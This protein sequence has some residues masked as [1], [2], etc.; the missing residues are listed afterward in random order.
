L[1]ASTNRLNSPASYDAAGHLQYW[2]GY[3]YSYNDLGQLLTATGTGVN[4]TYLYTASGERIADRNHL[5]NTTTLTLRN[6]D[7]HLLR[8]YLET[9]TSGNGNTTWVE[10]EVWGG[11]QL[12]GTI[13]PTAGKRYYAVDHLGTPRLI[14][15]RC[16]D[17]KAE[18]DYYAFGLEA[19]DPTQD[20]E[21]TRFTSQETDLQN[22]SG[23]TDD[24]VNMHARFYRPALARFLSADLLSGNP[25]RPQSFNLFAYVRGNPTNFWDPY[26]FGDDD[27]KVV[28]PSKVR[29][30]YPS[31]YFT[32]YTEVTAPFP[33]TDLIYLYSYVYPG[34]VPVVTWA[35]AAAA[36][37]TAT[38]SSTPSA[39]SDP[40][41][42]ITVPFAPAGANLAANIR[43]VQHQWWLGSLQLRL[44]AFYLHVHNHGPWDYKQI[45][46]LSDFGEL[47]RPSPYEDFG[48]F[49]YGA[50]GAAAGIPLWLVQRAAG[51]ASLRAESSR[52]ARLGH[53]WGAFPYGD[54]VRDQAEIIEG[55]YYYKGG[56]YK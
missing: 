54:E 36:S 12:L 32:G 1:N 21:P 52:A 29:P 34:G 25:H 53:P 23:Q 14:C 43:T 38:P 39:T 49:N 30:N 13:S 27:N 45:T 10:D 46:L 11:G 35:T 2:G 37:P 5:N 17:R 26:G 40:C 3:S 7:G 41:E 24:L 56:C 15:D 16:K 42:Q 20:A 19:S 50:T 9:G 31:L 33:W 47:E 51:L 48:N 6:L 55:Y 18:H 4:H 8:T 22:T 28:D 44:V